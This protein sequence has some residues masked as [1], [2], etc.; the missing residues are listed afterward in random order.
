[1]LSRDMLHCMYFS[2]SMSLSVSFDEHR[3]DGFGPDPIAPPVQMDP[4][5]LVKLSLCEPAAFVE[6]LRS[7]DE[8]HLRIRFAIFPDSSVKSIYRMPISC[9]RWLHRQLNI[10]NLSLRQAAVDVFK[11]FYCSLIDTCPRKTGSDVIWP[12]IENYSFRVVR[13][14]HSIG[15]EKA[16]IYKSPAKTM[17][18]Y[19]QP[20][21]VFSQGSP[22]SDIRITIENYAIL[23]TGLSGLMA[24]LEFSDPAFESCRVPVSRASFKL[25]MQDFDRNRF[26]KSA[27]VSCCDG[28]CYFGSAF[29]VGLYLAGR[30][31]SCD[32]GITARI[33]D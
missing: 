23:C 33:C 16:V 31:D 13:N 15:I 22:S 5:S 12:C 4:A 18:K 32:S 27:A 3:A 26:R 25:A 28:G 7:V 11:E 20:A 17:V 29:S 24:P 21:H 1:M 14:D 6:F 2:G 30:R 10:V 8:Y 19:V 9:P